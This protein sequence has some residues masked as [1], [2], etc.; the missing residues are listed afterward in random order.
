MYFWY[1]WASNTIYSVIFAIDL[2]I[3]VFFVWKCSS[4]GGKMEQVN[5]SNAV[6]HSYVLT[7]QSVESNLKLREQFIK[8]LE[9]NRFYEPATSVKGFHSFYH[10]PSDL[11]ILLKMGHLDSR[12]YIQ[13][14]SYNDEWKESVSMCEVEFA[15]EAILAIINLHK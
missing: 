13:L 10:E 4:Q 2:L 11:L 12:D 15:K 3:V 14:V 5:L 8:F 6:V 9:E 7:K 1:H